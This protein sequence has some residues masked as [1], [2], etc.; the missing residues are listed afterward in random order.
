MRRVV[1]LSILL[2]MG[3]TYAVTENQLLQILQRLGGNAYLVMVNKPQ[4]DASTNGPQIFVNRQYSKKWSIDEA[5]W[6]LGHELGHR[7][8]SGSTHQ[9]ELQSDYLGFL[10]AKRAGY[11]PCNGI[12]RILTWMPDSDH[13]D[14]Q[15]RYAALRKYC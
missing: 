6:T 14:P 2:L 7:L 4:I 1:F 11:N 10:Y 3:N 5:A 8:A 9:R 15:Y 13:P 12:K